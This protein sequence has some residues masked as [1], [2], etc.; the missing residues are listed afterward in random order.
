MNQVIP[1]ESLKNNIWDNF[2][3]KHIE[4]INNL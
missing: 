4:E 3:Q 1:S 2:I